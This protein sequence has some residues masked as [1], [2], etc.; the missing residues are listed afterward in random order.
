MLDRRIPVTSCFAW[1]DRERRGDGEIE[2]ER[3]VA[4]IAELKPLSA[5]TVH[6]TLAALKGILARSHIHSL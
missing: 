6:S 5:S 1:A 3:H 2:Q 4:A